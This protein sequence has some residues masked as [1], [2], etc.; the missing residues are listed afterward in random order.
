[1]KRIKYIH[2]G[3]VLPILFF[4]CFNVYAQADYRGIVKNEQDEPL[5]GVTISVIEASKTISKTNKNGG[6]SIK[7][8]VG[9]TLWFSYVGYAPYELKVGNSRDIEVVLKA[10]SNELQE[11]V[12][13]G[14]STVKQKDLT[15][16]VGV[17]RME[18]ALRTNVGNIDEALAGRIA[19]VQVSSN[20]GMPGE[21]ANIIIRGTNSVT[22]S[23]S[24]LYVVDGFPMEDFSLAS[25]NPN[26]IESISVLKDASATAIYGAR[27]ANGVVI[28]TSKKGVAGT[29]RVFFDS[30]YGIAD[31]TKTIPLMNAYEFVKLQSEIYTETD[32]AARYLRDG[33]TLEDYHNVPTL[34]WQDVVF[35]TAPV[36]SGTLNLSGGSNRTKYNSTLSIFDQDGIIKNSNYTR[37]QA[38]LNV[39]HNVSSKLRF[40]G[41]LN[42]SRIFQHGDS[43]SQ[44]LYTGSANL[45]PN[46]WSYR[47]FLKFGDI[48]L[49]DMLF[50]DE[51]VN[52][53]TDFRI[54]PLFITQEYTRKNTNDLRANAYLE[55][56]ILKDLKLKVSAGWSTNAWLRD[57]FNGA[58]SRQGNR[59][60]AEGINANVTSV[61]RTNFLNENTLTYN[62]FFDPDRKHAFD[63]LLGLTIQEGKYRY[64]YTK[65]IAIPN[66]ELGMTGMG[67]G[68]PQ[69]VNAD[70]SEWRLMSYLGRINYNYNSKYYLTASFRADGSTKFP[71]NNRWGY[72]PSF[73]VMWNLKEESFL[74]NVNEIST[75]K[76]RNSWGQTGNNR[77]G[78]YSYYAKMRS[79]I[80]SEGIY[81]STEYPFDD[82]YV[83]GVIITSPKNERL[84]WETSSQ[85]DIGIDM[86]FLNDKIKLTVDY[87]DKRT[88]GLLLNASLP[89]SYGFTTAIRNIG[90]IQ[91][92][93]FEFSLETFNIKRKNFSWSSNFNIAFNRNKVLALAENQESIV[94]VISYSNSYIAKIGNPLGQIYGYQYMGTYKYDDFDLIGDTY[95]L[96]EGIPNNGTDRAGIQPGDAKF[97]DVNG[98]GVVNNM[99]G[100]VTGNAVPR[101]IGGFSNT[102][103]YK[104]FDANIFLQWSYGNDVLNANKLA[105]GRGKPDREY[106]RWA[107]YSDRWTPDNPYSDIPRVGGWATGVYSS[108]E[109]EDASFLRLKSIS[110]GYNLPNNLVKKFSLR[111]LRLYGSVN[112]LITW[113][114]YTGYDPEVSTRNSA[115][116]P[117]YDAS[118]YPRARTITI[119]GNIIF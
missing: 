66:E 27:G 64:D 87:Y 56:D 6:F 81:A 80:T 100:V 11:T 15:G 32:F 63:A 103:K 85:W 55:Y 112:N 61:E 116:T 99:D 59:F 54:N 71:K 91:N 84:K 90:K 113:T 115:L 110:F 28:I 94:S 58:N 104:N 68:T 69:I 117:G 4:C 33:M 76:I 13:I 42:Y 60:R 114:K 74:Y 77:I 45:L 73:S 50:D 39:D 111:R 8:T 79:L 46:V 29:S 37:Y 72:F 35:Q 17:V 22:Q 49:M 101:H 119:G 65:V 2:R 88:D 14:Y 52:S 43:P 24:P 107:M 41:N 75:L 18:D 38:R 97:L 96:K 12:V 1:M 3:L 105:F 5:E 62:T 25:L 118:A 89:P 82:N 108:Y 78:D 93:G 36:K 98:D 53:S 92:S 67:A 44:T 109:V 26:D 19:G 102:F 86:G 30:N 21:Q 16:S 95:V 20:E 31:I 106:N 83:S 23:N 48:D 34:D 9:Q 10:V 40:N 57:Q 7:A 70:L 51:A 47:P